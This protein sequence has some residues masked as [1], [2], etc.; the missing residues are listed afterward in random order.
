[1]ADELPA[2]LS[3][4]PTTEFVEEVFSRIPYDFIDRFAVRQVLLAADLPARDARAR[5]QVAEEVRSAIRPWAIM[6]D[7]IAEHSIRGN[8]H[9]LVALYDSAVAAIARQHATE[10]VGQTEGQERTEG[11]GDG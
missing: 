1:M 7:G 10:P 2:P 3:A 11:E 8:A 4:G 6:R 5:A 9:P